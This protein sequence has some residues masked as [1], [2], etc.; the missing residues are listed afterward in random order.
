MHR[1]C[2]TPFGWIITETFPIQNNISVCNLTI[3][4]ISED[5]QLKK[6]WELEQVKSTPQYPSDDMACEALFEKDI[7]ISENGQFVAKFP[8][9][10]SP[11]PNLKI[12]E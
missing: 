8:L 10:C 7:H 9:K 4:H 6:F 2:N 11:Q 1:L 5:D 12:D 3:V